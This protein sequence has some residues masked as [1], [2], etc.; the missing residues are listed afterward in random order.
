MITTIANKSDLGLWHLTLTLTL[1]IDILPW[2]WSGIIL[3]LWRRNCQK[4][5][6]CNQPEVSTTSGS[7]VI[8]Q[9]VIFMVFDVFDLDL[10]IL[11]S[12]VPL[13]DW[14]KFRRDI[15]INSGDIAH[16]NMEKNTPYTLSWG[17]SLPRKR[18]LRFSD[19]CIFLQSSSDRSKQY[20]YKFWEESVENFKSRFSF[21]S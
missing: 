12:F 17:F 21:F 14:C 2:D 13:H 15:F 18:M 19:R 9:N 10:D 3:M 16:W 7:K 6:F 4:N 5:I 8:A 20:V 1:I 11:R